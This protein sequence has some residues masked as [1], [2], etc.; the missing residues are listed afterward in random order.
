MRVRTWEIEKAG[1][2]TALRFGRDDNFVARTEC[3]SSMSAANGQLCPGFG[4]GFSKQFA[5]QPAGQF[6]GDAV[7][8]VGQ[9]FAGMFADRLVFGLFR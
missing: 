7:D 5:G 6:S 2:S 3:F 4:Q 9:Q 1:P 8:S